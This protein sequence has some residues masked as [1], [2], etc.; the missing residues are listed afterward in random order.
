MDTEDCSC[1]LFH[2]VS[3]SSLALLLSSNHFSLPA[4]LFL[5]YSLES[6]KQAAVGCNFVLSTQPPPPPPG[7]TRREHPLSVGLGHSCCC[8]PRKG[9]KGPG[10]LSQQCAPCGLPRDKN[11][12]HSVPSLFYSPS[13]AAAGPSPIRAHGL[14]GKWQDG[15]PACLRLIAA[16]PP[17]Q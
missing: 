11:L 15:S 4:L 8:N 7:K 14:L 10:L 9:G 3:L 5:F 17:I 16:A 12:A 13:L 1:M 2:S 6:S